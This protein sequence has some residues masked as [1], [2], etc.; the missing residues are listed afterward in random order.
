MEEP[1]DNIV[2]SAEQQDTAVLLERLLGRAIA[3]R[4]IDFSRL[5]ASATGLRVSRPLA[6][7]ALRELESMLR[8]SLEVPMHAK[9]LPTEAQSG[10]LKRAVQALQALGFEDTLIENAVDELVPRHSHVTQIKLIAERLGL[11]PD[12]DIATAWI[13]LRDTV[14]RA[15]ERSFHRTLAV[16]DGFRADYQ[17]PFELVLGGIVTALQKRYTALMQRVEALAGMSDHARAVAL[18][19]REIPGALPLQWHFFQSITSPAWL[20]HLLKRNLISEPL[21][22]AGAAS[23]RL[24][25]EWPVGYYLLT[26]AKSDDVAA[27]RLVAEAI[28]I[29][30]PSKHPDVRRIGMEVIAALSVSIAAGLVD[31]AVGW[32]DPDTPDFYSIAPEQLIKKLAEGGHVDEAL[33]LAAALFQLFDRNGHL[34]TLHPQ[35]MYEHHLPGAVNVLAPRNG[36]AT[37]RLFARRLVQAATISRKMS[38]DGDYSHHTPDPISDSRMASYGVYEALVIAVRDSAL[39]ACENVPKTTSD[40]VSFLVNGE[41]KILKRIALHVVAKHADA[42]SELAFA[43][44]A[45]PT[46]VGENWCEDEYAELARARFPTL[47]S[48][49]RQTIFDVIDALPDKFRAQWKES[50]AAHYNRPPTAED[51]RLFDLSVVRDAMWKW[52]DVLPPDRKALIDA[53]VAQIGNPDAWREQLFPRETSPLN[54][55][56]FASRPISEVIAFLHS[57]QPQTEPVRQTITALGQQLRIAVEQECDRF[58]HVADRFAGLRPIYVRRLL[59]GFDA[60]ARNNG[61]FAWGPVLKLLESVAARLRQPNNTFLAVEG[62]DK[63]WRWAC[64]AS[65]SLLKSGLRHGKDGIP[66]EHSPEVLSIILTLFTNAPREPESKD[67]ETLFARQP[68]SA[69]EQSLWGSAIVLCILF[70]FWA[71]KHDISMR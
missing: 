20:P 43:L 21:G 34:V 30:A 6:A 61:K 69:A 68:Y 24:F 7:H 66:Y 63:D 49:Q 71:S 1:T 55:A 51:E 54:G 46:Y 14:G 16:D 11:A 18:F 5:A 58:A 3:D 22:P 44:L 29:V 26:L 64:S 52:Q 60:K 39:I 2:L 15:H 37:L 47:S 59:E 45:D 42:V 70:V 10:Q 12:G 65:A 53:S 31:V 41:P 8:R 25:G 32:L 62:D 56:D 17:R 23:P 40:V 67:F 9:E 57:W 4:Y 13:S 27:H 48:D 33:H 38:G 50:F 36:A 35:H 28:R 19:E